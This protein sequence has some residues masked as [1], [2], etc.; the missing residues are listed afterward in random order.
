MFHLFVHIYRS[1]IYQ[2]CVFVHWL[3]WWSED[4]FGNSVSGIKGYFGGNASSGSVRGG[5]NGW[6]EGSSDGGS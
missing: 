4:H 3:L 5:S 1:I 2:I 6:V